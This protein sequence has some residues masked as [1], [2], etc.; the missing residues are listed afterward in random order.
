M[1]NRTK[2]RILAPLVFTLVLACFASAR[3]VIIT[4]HAKL[5]NGP[6][7]EPGAYRIEIVKDQAPPE[8]LFYK[9][10]DLV[11]RNPVTLAEETG[12]SRHTE[13]HCENRDGGPVITWIR[14]QGWR[15][16]LVFD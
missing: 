3:E 9:G 10:G 1:N 12:K 5:G 8:V 14:V 4:D 6:R 2:F 13:V 7:L 11:L 16:S 15:E